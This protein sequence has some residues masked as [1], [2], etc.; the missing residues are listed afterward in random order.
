MKNISLSIFAAAAL[1]AISS[2]VQ[3]QAIEANEQI[4]ATAV[5]ATDSSAGG[6]LLLPNQSRED[7]VAVLEKEEPVIKNVAHKRSAK[8]G[9]MVNGYYQMPGERDW[10]TNARLNAYGYVQYSAPAAYNP[11]ADLPVYP[12]GVE[13][14]ADENGLETNGTAAETTT[15]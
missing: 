13:E 11:D 10:G 2:N 5:A 15:D 7:A 12:A 3:A 8:I 6:I 9:K 4:S 14:G 1:F